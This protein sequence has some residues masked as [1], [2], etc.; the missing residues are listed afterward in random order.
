MLESYIIMIFA[1]Y[2]IE[3]DKKSINIAGTN[4]EKTKMKNFEGLQFSFFLYNDKIEKKAT[5]V[6]E[7][8][9]L[10]EQLYS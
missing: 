10:A 6:T 8:T 2:I 4:R 3:R 9:A 7:F 5:V 1:K